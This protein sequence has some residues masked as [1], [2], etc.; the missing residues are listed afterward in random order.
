MSVARGRK[1]SH[2]LYVVWE[3][4]VKRCSNPRSGDYARYGGRGISVC[5]RWR[6]D[7]WNFVDDMGPRPEGHSIDRIDNDGNYEPENCRW[8]SDSEQRRNKR[9]NRYLTG[10]NGEKMV[11]SDWAV[12]NGIP[13][14]TIWSRID[15]GWTEE[16]AVSQAP[17][18]GNT[19]L[20]DHSVRDI[21]DRLSRGESQA[22]I[23]R[24]YE[25]NKSTI[26][27]IANGRR[28][29]HVQ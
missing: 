29:T 10:P 27:M 13:V 25:V 3:G 9:T 24:K 16:R 6:G 19:R 2:E 7:F 18:V 28:W 22:S 20:T 26:G 1:K 11:M 23:A 12:V 15:S 4:M 14:E 21:K 17:G 8:A 5:E